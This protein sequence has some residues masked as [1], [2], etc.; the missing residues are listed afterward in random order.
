MPFVDLG[1]PVL[2]AISRKDFIGALTLRR[3]R[4]RDA[5]TLAAVA[6]GVDRGASIVRVHDVAAVRDY[7]TVRAALRG[8][9][10]VDPTLTLPIELR[11]EPP[12]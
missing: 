1:R 9:R 6:D 11:R 8:D 12:A 5:G 10:P 3:P 2:L 4:G 7:L